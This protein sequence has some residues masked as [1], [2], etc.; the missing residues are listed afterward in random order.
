MAESIQIPEAA[1]KL[2]ELF[3]DAGFELFVV[4]GAVRDRVLGLSSFDDDIDMTTDARP[5]DVLRLIS[6]LASAVWR[7]GERFGTI[8]ANVFDRS[9]EITTYRSES[10]EGHSRKPVVGF[11]DDLETDLSRRDFTINAMALSART[12]E[13]HD[14]FSG[15]DDLAAKILRTPLSPEVSF[16]DDPLRMLR[17]ARFAA[18]LGLRFDG[19]VVDAAKVLAPRMEIVSGER[20]FAE[21]E[22]LLELPDPTAGLEFLWQTGVLS[23]AFDRAQLAP[24]S[25]VEHA[26]NRMATVVPVDTGVRW[27]ALCQLTRV[28]VD[29]LGEHLRMSTDRR[30][31]LKI[32]TTNRIP[33]A[34]DPPTLRRMI[35]WLGRAQVN[36][37]VA[38]E[39]I[40]GGMPA[41]H[42]ESFLTAFNTREEREPAT[43]LVSPLSGSD[44]L[45]LLNI[46]PGP[47]VGQIRLHLE[48]LAIEN[49]PLTRDQAAV[50]AR[51]FLDRQ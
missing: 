10:Y 43:D 11:G 31:D 21:I 44:I 4:G 38:V 7:Q 3:H 23:A 2:G 30:K 42:L 49:G 46:E 9:V 50:A 12:G 33:P 28:E 1:R 13:L 27:A 5:P 41:T 25:T 22:R 26:I 35:L 45:D 19:A 15:V 17:A 39:M 8:G 16:N 36:R 20:I 48:S 29:D 37:V 24:Y 47:L 32:L 51:N 34:F 14:P 40:V 18:R 6:P